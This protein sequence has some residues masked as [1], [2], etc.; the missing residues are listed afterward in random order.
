ML[1]AEE[2][3]RIK[4]LSIRSRK[5]VDSMLGGRWRSVFKGHG[6]EFEEVREYV[7]GDEVKSID[8]R[9]SA[10]MNRPFVKLFREEREL[11]VMPVVDLSASGRFGTFSLL[12]REKAAEAA[13]VLAFAAMRNNDKVGCLLFTDRVER[14]IPPKKGPSHIWRVIREVMEA[15]PEGTGT[16]ITAA[17]DYL[18]RVVRKRCVAFLISDF[19]DQGYAGRLRIAAG[20][21]EVIAVNVRDPGEFTLPR[22]IVELTDPETGRRMVVD[23]LDSSVRRAWE[24]KALKEQARILE[25]LRQARV[26]VVD[27]STGDSV[28]EAFLKYFFARERRAA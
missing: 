6:M 7:P 15:E 28:S 21:H 27:L 26:D 19:L 14:F 25:T 1:P 17:L 4:K 5:A 20:R 11:T 10:R 2:I 13:A 22:G 9:V 16:D 3:R 23:G 18:G 24:F 8:W 12:K